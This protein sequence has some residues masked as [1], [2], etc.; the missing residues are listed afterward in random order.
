MEQDTTAAVTEQISG[1]L[2]TF[3]GL[4]N[5]L[6]QTW[7]LYQIGILIGL[8]VFAWC[9]RVV[10]HQKLRSMVGKLSGWPKPVLRIFAI[11]LQRLQLIAFTI[12]CW[13]TYSSMQI[14][15]WPSRSYFIGVAASLATAW[16][17]IA[18]IAPLIKNRLIRKSVKWG[19]W[20]YATV[21]ILDIQD[22]VASTLD[23][24]A[25][26]L[27]QM[28][29]SLLMLITAVI[30][31]ALFFGIASILS[32]TGSKRIQAL[33]DVSPSIRVLAV[34]IFQVVVFGIAFMMALTAIGFDLSNLALLSGAIGL[35]IGFGLQKIVSNLVSGVIILLDKSIKPGDVISLE[36]TFGWITQLGA[37]YASVETRDGREYLIPNEDFITNQ[38][39]NWTHSSDFIRLDIHFGVAYHSDPHLVKKVA[40]LAPLTV[41]RVV[42]KPA[43]VC[44]I[45]NFGDSSIDFK[46]RFWIKDPTSGLTNI[47]GN[48]YLA[49]W[50]TLKE[51]NIDIP[52]P[53][54]DLHMYAEPKP[55]NALPND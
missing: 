31:L 45:I 47:R 25:L 18:I 52:F 8:M 10:L 3:E 22:G 14:L 30:S 12:L 40:S 42:N 17:I 27:G 41:D 48:V 39:V 38:V 49:L 15:T 50:D 5:R 21:V 26:N 24:A 11:L 1:L 19:L 13:I 28:R 51:N 16:L 7:S 35:G 44:H 23:A 29:V 34:K 9:I 43:P 54:R 33:E 4:F 6:M 46:L 32:K 55:T 36:G 53:R 20:I 37:R 2:N